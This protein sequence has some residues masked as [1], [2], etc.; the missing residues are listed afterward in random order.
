MRY[1][2]LAMTSPAAD[3]SR[4]TMT[5]RGPARAAA[6]AVLALVLLWPAVAHAQVKAVARPGHSRRSPSPQS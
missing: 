6:G 4:L 1:T 3:V 2:R 5:L